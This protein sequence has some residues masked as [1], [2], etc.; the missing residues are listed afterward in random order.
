MYATLFI[1]LSYL[2][3][4]ES[5]AQFVGDVTCDY[6]LNKSEWAAEGEAWAILDPFLGMPYCTRNDEST[7]FS[8]WIDSCCVA[9]KCTG[10]LTGACMNTALLADSNC[11]CNYAT[12]SACA[13]CKIAVEK[14]L[15]DM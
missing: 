9:E 3:P 5:W 14:V 2:G 11:A 13:G 12:S 8:G 4:R 15:Y 6:P 10:T 1:L 7:C